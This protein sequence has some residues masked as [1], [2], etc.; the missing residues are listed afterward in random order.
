M[1]DI[2]A[3]R[4]L[5]GDAFGRVG[6]LV[7]GITSDLSPAVATYRPDQGANTIAWLVWH[8]TRVQDD[9]IADL[10]GGEQV[11]PAWRDRFG[12]PFDDDATGYGQSAEQVG[13]VQVAGDLLAGYHRDVQK[14]TSSYVESLTGEELERVVDT[15]WDPP[16]TASVR[17]VSV[18]GDITQHLGQAYYVKGLAER[19]GVR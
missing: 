8:A 19:A 5:V 6:E 12:L 1:S 4:A 10:V 2:D 17:L 15:H 3:L 18:I 14:F 9:H 7:D 13:Q 16:V 11:W